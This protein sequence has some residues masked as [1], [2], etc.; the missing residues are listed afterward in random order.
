MENHTGER[1]RCQGAEKASME[2]QTEDSDLGNAGLDQKPGAGFNRGTC[3][4]HIVNKPNHRHGG[5]FFGAWLQR[6]CLSGVLE[7]PGTV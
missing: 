7:T 2:A 5:K 4:N 6:V 1:H 3:S